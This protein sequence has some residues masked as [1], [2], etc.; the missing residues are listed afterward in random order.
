MSF[1]QVLLLEI[2]RV[3]VRAS[4]P[5]GRN[6]TCHVC[7]HHVAECRNYMYDV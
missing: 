7:C 2:H 6:V 4:A 1:M 3:I 5:S